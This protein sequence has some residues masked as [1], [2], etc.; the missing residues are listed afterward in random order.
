MRVPL[1]ALGGGLPAPEAALPEKTGKLAFEL[2]A[3]VGQQRARCM[4]QQGQAPIESAGGVSGVLGRERHGEGE[5]Q[6]RVDQGDDGA[7]VTMERRIPSQ[8]RSRVSQASTFRAWAETCLGFLG[9]MCRRRGL[10]RPRLS[11]RRG[12]WRL[13]SGRGP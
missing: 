1:R 3:V 13:L 8:M 6:D 12:A 9:F 11:M 2:T 4:G 5:V 10:L 7:K